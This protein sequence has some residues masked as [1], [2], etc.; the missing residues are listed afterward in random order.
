MEFSLVEGKK[1]GSFHYISQGYRYTPTQIY[2]GARYLR[3]TLWRTDPF[4]CPGKAIITEASNLL[5]MKLEHNHTQE[6][7]KS[8]SI[9]LNNKLKR[10]AE[11]STLNLREVFDK[12]TSCEP[13]GATVSYRH[14]RNTMVKRR[15]TILPTLPKTPEE[16][17]EVIM[18]SRFVDSVRVSVSLP[19]NEGI[20]VLFISNLMV[21]NLKQAKSINFDATFYVVPKIFYQL[22]TI[23]IKHDGH[24]FPCVHVLMSRKTESLYKAVMEKILEIRPEFKADFAV[25]DYQDASRNAFQAIIPSI[26]VVGCLFHFSQAIWARAKKLK[27]S[28]AYSKNG[29][30]NRW[31]KCIM[32]LPLLPQEEI[33][34]VL[35][36]LSQEKI[37]LS[38]TDHKAKQK[39]LKYIIKEWANKEGVSVYASK[40]KTNNACEIYHKAL[41]SKIRVKRPNIWSF[42]EHLEEIIQKYD[43]EFQRLENGLDISDYQKQQNIENTK[44]REACRSK[45]ESQKLTPIDYLKE[46]SSTI[47][48][49]YTNKEESA[50]S[51]SSSESSSEEIPQE[52]Y[53]VVC[54]SERIITYI[55]I[56]CAHANICQE[57]AQKFGKGMKCPT[58]RAIISDKFRVFT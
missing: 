40:D 50:Y 6:N 12:T 9:E 1:L 25:G 10:A 53:C 57:C 28:F 15:K 21:A 37:E 33:T 34:P 11:N 54:L 20:A 8:E 38:N 42:M 36:M 47:G 19:E 4:I 44:I 41:K 56:P 18:Q 14:V 27:L 35:T 13:A 29:D 16:F 5:N 39:L 31:L 3:C 17:K 7:Y 46:I 55:F 2:G 30:F 45:L 58:C 32:A 24:F 43:L 22:F 26:S 48:K 23:F 52:G 51:S 49:H